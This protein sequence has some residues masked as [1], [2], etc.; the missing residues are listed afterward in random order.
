[1]KKLVSTIKVEWSLNIRN[2][3]NVFFSLVFPVMMLLLFGSIYG[4]EPSTYYGGYGSVDVLTPGYLGMVIAVAGLMTLP[5]TLS[6]YR[7]RKIL[8]RFKATPMGPKEIL[9]SQFVVNTVVT[10]ISS[11]ILIVV[12]IIVF[13]L[14][15]YGNVLLML[16]AYLLVVI[17]L[18]SLG[19][20]IASISKNAKAALAISYVIYFPMLF[21]SG[22]TLPLEFMPNGIKM[23]SKGLPLTY[24]VELMKG[25][26]LGKALSDF[27]MHIGVLLLLSLVLIIISYKTFKYE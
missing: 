24:G 3:L 19:L 1:M 10:M 14:K 7:E 16:L 23:I 15:F 21:L 12:G 5:I 6:Q 9:I 26:W 25:L 18:F 13:H 27:T 22:A 2:F 17:N 20:C 11:L 8:K 4:N